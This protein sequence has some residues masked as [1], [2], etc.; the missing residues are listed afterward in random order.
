MD[1]ISSMEWKTWQVYSLGKGIVLRF[2]L[3]E[4]ISVTMS[5]SVVVRALKE[6]WNQLTL[7][8]IGWFKTANQVNYNHTRA[9]KPTLDGLL[10]LN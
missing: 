7:D 5:L 1:Q 4:S 3:N 6:V 10:Q 2:D 8:A 9:I